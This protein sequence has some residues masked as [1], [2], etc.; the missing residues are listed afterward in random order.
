MFEILVRFVRC[1]TNLNLLGGQVGHCSWES[2]L[3][4]V[5]LPV[6]LTNLQ[7]E[8]ITCKTSPHCGRCWKCCLVPQSIL[9]ALYRKFTVTLNIFLWNKSKF[10]FTY[11]PSTFQLYEDYTYRMR[12][13]EHVGHKQLL[14][15]LFP[16]ISPFVHRCCCCVSHSRIWMEELIPICILWF[17]N[18]SVFSLGIYKQTNKLE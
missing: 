8:H 15:I 7:P 5:L 11:F 16:N 2:G 6:E 4:W 1:C 10:P 9:E 14:V 17:C 18:W 3:Q 12:L 13:G